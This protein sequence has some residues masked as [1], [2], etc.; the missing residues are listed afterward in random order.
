[1]QYTYWTLGRQG[2]VASLLVAL[3][4]V[5]LPGTSLTGDSVARAAEAHHATKAP[6]TVGAGYE[7]LNGSSRVRVLQKRLRMLGHQLGPV[8]G[9]YGP[10]TK[11]AVERFQRSA[12]LQVDG[13]AGPRTLTALEAAS[14]APV[15]RG[16]GYG[17]RGGSHQVRALQRELKKAGQRPG[18]VDGL[19]GPRTEQAVLK[20]QYAMDLAADGVV[21]PQTRRALER[22]VRTRHSSAAR[23]VDEDRRTERAIAAQSLQGADATAHARQSPVAGPSAFVP[24]PSRVSETNEH[25]L[26]MLGI[27]ALAVLA[28]TLG[29]L[30]RALVSRL[31]LARAAL[32]P[33]GRA[34]FGQA[35]GPGR[36]RNRRT[37]GLR[38]FAV[39]PTRS[40]PGSAQRQGQSSEEPPSVQKADEGGSISQ[41]S[42]APP[43]LEARGRDLVR[44]VGYV[45]GANPAAL[46][47]PDIRKQIA[48]IGAFCDERGWELTEIVRDVAAQGERGTAPGLK[49]ALERLAAVQPSCLVTGELRRLGGSPAELGHVVRLLRERDQ[50]LVAVNADLDTGTSEGRLAADA[51]IS[52]GELE[53]ARQAQ[54]TGEAGAQARAKGWAISRPAVR[55]LPA[56]TKHIVAMRSAGMTLQAI[57]DRLNSEGMPTLRGG[58]K[59]RP[60][61]VQVAAGYRRPGQPSRAGSLPKGAVRTGRV[62]GM[63]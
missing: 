51:L 41:P 1:M 17:Q 53:H 11:A 34:I 37:S 6:L 26:D 27:L 42:T 19:F 52:V 31:T 61:S 5:C 49:Y 30:G 56:L 55:N 15:A 44:A 50:R 3:L 32:V 58:K 28:F 43:L 2:G 63:D 4:L 36:S 20:F 12:G 24:D 33:E 48:A 39:N 62:G 25:V 46:S 60:S 9:L 18:P 14:P 10:L 7:R 57:A 40:S 29:S 23:E 22:T 8:D 21:G 45:S 16:A 38:A 35:G 47:G 54:H 13:I 59:W